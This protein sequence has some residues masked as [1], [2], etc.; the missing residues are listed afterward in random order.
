MFTQSFSISRVFSLAAA[1]LAAT[2]AVGLADT[3][4]ASVIYSDNFPGTSTAALNG[5]SPAT[6]A[7]AA[8]WSAPL[9]PGSDGWAA[10]GATTNTTTHAAALLSFTPVSGN[11][12]TLSATLDPTG[13]NSNWIALGFANAKQQCKNNFVC[14]YEKAGIRMLDMALA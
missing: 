3:A 2:V 14:F 7:T 8:T 1:V 11:V 6:D 5:T 4:S 9:A 10:N 13:G 12:Y